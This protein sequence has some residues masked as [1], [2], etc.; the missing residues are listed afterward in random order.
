[1]E[2]L[3][4]GSGVR[5]ALGGPYYGSYKYKTMIVYLLLLD[6]FSS[7]IPA[8]SIVLSSSQP[9]LD[10]KFADLG[11][12]LDEFIYIKKNTVDL[13]CVVKGNE[14]LIQPRAHDTN[15][16]YFLDRRAYGSFYARPEVISILSSLYKYDVSILSKGN[17]FYLEYFGQDLLPTVV[18]TNKMLH[19]IDRSGLK[20][21]A[22]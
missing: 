3:P 6:E 11:L 17:D 5:I 15:T 14:D 18:H 7:K 22:V 8:G 13:V 12:Q 16:V 10:L 1:M 21:H 4:P 2:L 20:I 9:S 19:I